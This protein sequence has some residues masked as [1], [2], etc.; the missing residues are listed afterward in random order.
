LNWSAECGVVIPCLNEAATI[1]AL[2]AAV[3]QHLE[4]VVV[5]DDGSTDATARLAACAGAAV[6]RHDQ[7]E[8]KGAA[9]RTGLTWLH[10]R[11]LPWALLMD[12]DGQH[13]PGDIPK[14]LHFAGRGAVG[15]ISGERMSAAAEM[16]WLRRAVNRWLSRRLSAL[17]GQRIP[18]SQCGFRLL[19]LAL[20]AALDLET[21]HFEVES[22]LLYACASA[23]VPIHF[24]PVQVIYAAERSKVRPLRDSWRWFCWWWVASQSRARARKLSSVSF[25]ESLCNF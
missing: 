2:V 4:T 14:F 17:T 19:R 8:G 23:G 5:V 7:V 20:W 18:D 12:G 1:A 15:L 9:L 22:E 25:P 13:A 3:R 6:L 10:Q 11:Q 21:N 24:V 16:P